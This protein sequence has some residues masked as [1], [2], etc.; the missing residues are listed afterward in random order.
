MKK[1]LYY[2]STGGADLIVSVDSDKNCL[3][4]NECDWPAFPELS[5]Y[6]DKEMGRIAKEFLEIV[7][8]DY[9]WHDDCTCDD[10]HNFENGLEF[11][12]MAHIEK[13]LQSL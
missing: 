7:E 6:E 5:N 13:E 10:F 12:I 9:N 3:Y 2:I 1:D 8:N 4:L 11:F